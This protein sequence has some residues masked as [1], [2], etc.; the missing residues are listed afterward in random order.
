[1]AL[2]IKLSADTTTAKNEIISTKGLNSKLLVQGKKDQQE[3]NEQ[4]RENP[5]NQKGKS[6][7]K[8]KPDDENEPKREAGDGK[9]KTKKEGG[10]QDEYRGKGTPYQKKPEETPPD[11]EVLKDFTK[12]KMGSKRK[13]NICKYTVESK[14]KNVGDNDAEQS[15]LTFKRSDLKNGYATFDIDTNGGL[16]AGDSTNVKQKYP[17]RDK[18]EIGEG[19]YIWTFT[20]KKVPGETNTANNEISF[21]CDCPKGRTPCQK[22]LGAPHLY[23]LS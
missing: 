23:A 22:K 13:G 18:A 12:V 15:T 10:D 2:S 8:G 6:K 14:V 20:V 16:E 9:Y 17:K 11:L 3:E 1:M 7:S 5:E 4:W 19:N 21:K